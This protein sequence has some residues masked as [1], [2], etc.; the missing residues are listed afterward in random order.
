[1]KSIESRK[2]CPKCK[3]NWDGGSILDTFKDQRNR[4]VYHVGKSDEQLESEM[5]SMYAEPYRWSR[6][7]GIE[8][9][10]EYDGISYWQC[11]DCKT[12]WSRFTGEEK[13]FDS[14]EK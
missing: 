13:V 1:M 8:I 2:R 4:G 5:K 14:H 9:Q 7:I 10:G 11:P 3:S 12:Y 6:L